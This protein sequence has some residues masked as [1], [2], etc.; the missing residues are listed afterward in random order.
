M[1][2][3]IWERMQESLDKSCLTTHSWREIEKGL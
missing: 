2:R 3:V 1:T